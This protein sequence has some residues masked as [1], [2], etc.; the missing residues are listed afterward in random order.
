MV[1]QSSGDVK[2]RDLKPFRGA[3]PAGKAVLGRVVSVSSRPLATASASGTAPQPALPATQPQKGGSKGKLALKKG[4]KSKA[5]K[6]RASFSDTVMEIYLCGG[7]TGMDVVLFEVW[8]EDLRQRL[9]PVARVGAVVR[10]KNCQVVAHTDKTRWYTTSR[11]PVYVKALPQVALEEAADDPAFVAYHP[12]TPISSLYRLEAKTL[13]CVAGRVVPPAPVVARVRT[14]ED[15]TDVEVAHVMLRALDDVVKITFWRDTAAMATAPEMAVG[16]LVMINGVAKQFPGQGVEARQQASLRA[17]ARTVVTACPDAL[18]QTLER[19]PNT[20][21][22]ARLWSPEVSARRDYTTAPAQ[23]VTLS[24][25]EKLCKAPGVRD[26]E[27]VFQVPSV[28][29]ELEDEPT[30]MACSKCFKA[31]PDTDWTPCTCWPGASA[32][33]RVPR[34]RGKIVMRDGTASLKATCFNAFQL[35]ADIAAGEAGLDPATP[36]GWQSHEVVA[37]AMSYVSAVPLTM[38]VTLAGD[39]WA[40]SMQATVQLVQKT[41]SSGNVSHPLKVPLHLTPTEGACP[42]CELAASS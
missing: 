33:A 24:V 2:P 38:R 15:T 4:G 12:V 31:W 28:H 34:W 9:A 21:V 36:E 17:V 19:T 42:P 11:L 14:A 20:D 23:W 30:Y 18:R 40:T 8:D 26:I 13:V 37:K 41:F 16:S 27:K 35:I 3:L 7:N 25:L 10:V 5:G 22:G 1:V 6:G 39:A 32:E 29:I